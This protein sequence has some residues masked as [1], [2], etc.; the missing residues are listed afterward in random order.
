MELF[1]FF[2]T[3]EAWSKCGGTLAVKKRNNYIKKRDFEWIQL[4]STVPN[5][6]WRKEWTFK[7]VNLTVRTEMHQKSSFK[8]HWVQYASSLFV[9]LWFSQFLFC[10][11]KTHKH[12]YRFCFS[13]IYYTSK[14]GVTTVFTRQTGLLSSYKSILEEIFQTVS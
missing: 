3:G 10:F 13:A 11:L 4:A 1:Y 6:A 7:Q 5:K 9:L 8:L 12:T 14:E 2:H